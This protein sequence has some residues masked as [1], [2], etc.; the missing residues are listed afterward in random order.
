[1]PD[2]LVPIIDWIIRTQVLEQISEVDAK[3]LFHNPYFLVPFIC[4]VIYY[5]YKQAVNNLV[6]MGLGIGLWFF[7]G[8]DYVR[9][10]VVGDQLQLS[11]VLPIVGV[12]M[13]GVAIM[14]Y[15]IFIR[16]D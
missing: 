5:L 14:V 15:L 4:L 11:R 9:T 1:M 2:F 13:A 3:A 8:T 10:A 6:I 7:S 16:Q 12:G